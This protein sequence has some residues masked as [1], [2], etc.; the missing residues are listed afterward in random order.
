MSKEI[1]ELVAEAREVLGRINIHAFP[2][3][4]AYQYRGGVLG[5]NV[6][7]I[8]RDVADALEATLEGPSASQVEE[9]D[10][11]PEPEMEYRVEYQVPGGETHISNTMATFE[12]AYNF[13]LWNIHGGT[14][15]GRTKAIPAGPWL[16]VEGEKP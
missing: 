7:E 10:G 11:A 15:M 5:R 9:L 6:T 1:E 13:M 8:L 12:D 14:V 3:D 16:P 4:L 2:H